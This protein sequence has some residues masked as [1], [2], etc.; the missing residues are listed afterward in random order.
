VPRVTIKQVPLFQRSDIRKSIFVCAI[1][2]EPSGLPDF[3]KVPLLRWRTSVAKCR[4]SAR[5]RCKK[6][7]NRVMRELHARLWG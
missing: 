5:R 6:C 1:C 7:T 3:E 4:K 2:G